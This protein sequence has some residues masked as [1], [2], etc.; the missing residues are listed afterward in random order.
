[1]SKILLVDDERDIVEFLQYNL[2]QKG[3]EVIVGYDG[4][5]ALKKLSENPDLIILDIMMPHLDGYDVYKKI[6]ENEKFKNIPIIF[7]TA[8]SGEVDEIKALELG[9]SDYVQKPISPKKL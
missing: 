8:K 6:R 4:L 2:E 7:L 1:M 5:E 9:A 3:Y